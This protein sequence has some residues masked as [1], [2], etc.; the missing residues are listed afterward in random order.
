M[1]NEGSNAVCKAPPRLE[2]EYGSLAG[3]P[4]VEVGART[5][6]DGKK[7]KELFEDVSVMVCE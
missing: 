2:T 1:A 7:L 4:S 3:C 6:Q 5:G